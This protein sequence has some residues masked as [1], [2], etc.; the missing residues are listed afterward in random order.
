MRYFLIILHGGATAYVARW[1]IFLSIG[2]DPVMSMVQVF[3]ASCLLAIIYAVGAEP[4][5]WTRRFLG[6]LN[7]G[8][9]AGTVL[10]TTGHSEGPVYR[11]LA[12]R[13][14][15]AFDELL[16]G[17][18]ILFGLVVSI[19][20]LLVRKHQTSLTIHMERWYSLELLSIIIWSLGSLPWLMAIIRATDSVQ[21]SY[22]WGGA[23][24]FM[25]ITTMVALCIA[26]IPML[27]ASRSAAGVV[28]L[29]VFLV[30]LIARV[31]GW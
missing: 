20:M 1:T 28:F 25:E 11:T 7:L 15:A 21:E 8:A 5:N 27:H 30:P 10:W 24:Y 9:V 19:S 4:T 26:T 13:P 16:I 3:S 31:N 29:E 14:S 17:A 23:L 12:A 6:L 22:V 2:A 18:F